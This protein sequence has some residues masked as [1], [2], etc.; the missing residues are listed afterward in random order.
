MT[1]S[2]NCQ[3]SQVHGSACAAE[4]CP[5]CQ[6]MQAGGQHGACPRTTA[7]CL[8]P[9]G[10]SCCRGWLHAESHGMRSLP[11]TTHTLSIAGAAAAVASPAKSPFP[12]SST[13]VAYL[14]FQQS[15]GDSTPTTQPSSRE[16]SL[17]LQLLL[18]PGRLPP[19]AALS[20]L[21][22]EVHVDQ[23]GCNDQQQRQQHVDGLAAAACLAR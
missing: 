17:L 21:L 14:P 12:R 16:E 5:S 7:V 23:H 22:G 4:G 9:P 2:L 6:N 19:A 20:L 11:G 18:K 10:L 15:D 8:Q 13:G 1:L 3:T